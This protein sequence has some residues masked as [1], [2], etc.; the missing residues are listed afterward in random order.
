VVGNRNK[1]VRLTEVDY[2][3]MDLLHLSI[4]SGLC[5]L[6]SGYMTWRAWSVDDDGWYLFTAFW[7][8]FTLPFVG[9]LLYRSN[10]AEAEEPAATVFTS[11]SA[12]MKMVYFFFISL[13]AAIFIPL[14][15]R[16]N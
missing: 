13:L 15:S 6:A 9:I 5:S 10:Q 3:K 11:H 14:C 8:F 16:G 2:V 4:I 1:P 7:L 12:R